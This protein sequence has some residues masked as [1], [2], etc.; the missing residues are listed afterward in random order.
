MSTR[1]V[2][3][4]E[5]MEFVAFWRQHKAA[6]L[7]GNVCS[8]E[9]MKCLH[10]YTQPDNV[11]YEFGMLR[12]GKLGQWDLYDI[13]LELLPEKERLLISGLSAREVAI[14]DRDQQYGLNPED[15]NYQK[16]V[17]RV[18][19]MQAMSPE[20]LDCEIARLEALLS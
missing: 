5:R 17:A 10:T 18:E 15:P 2:T 16:E 13:T 8:E 14:S 19:R 4:Q 20:E 3:E 9:A 7:A 12:P 11:G 1:E 6:L